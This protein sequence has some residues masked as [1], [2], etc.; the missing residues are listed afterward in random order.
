MNQ[1]FKITS[2]LTND[3]V[4]TVF[5][6]FDDIFKHVFIDCANNFSKLG[7]KFSKSSSVL[8]E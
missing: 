7:F 2:F 5:N 6:K 1:V 3:R 8:L 4:H